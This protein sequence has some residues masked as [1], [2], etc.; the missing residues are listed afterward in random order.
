MYSIY[1]T[2]QYIQYK[3][4]STF[5][6]HWCSRTGFLTPTDRA[7]TDESIFMNHK[8]LVRFIKRNRLVWFS[9]LRFCTLLTKIIQLIKTLDLII[10]F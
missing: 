2:V 5:R 1:S 3:Q 7:H 10:Y 9:E 6:N 8:P 4:Y